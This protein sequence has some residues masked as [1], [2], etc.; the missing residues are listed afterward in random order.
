M[1]MHNGGQR[2]FTLIEMLL[3]V[4]IMG[5][6]ASIISVSVIGLISKGEE[7]GY[8]VDERVLQSAVSVFYADVHQY[9]VGNGGWNEEGNWT[10]A[11]NHPTKS[12]RYLQLREGSKIYIDDH[13]VSVLVNSYGQPATTEEVDDASI[14]IGLLVNKPST[15]TTGLDKAPGSGNSPLHDEHGPYINEVPKSCSGLNHI[16][17]DGS[18][19]WIVGNYGRVYGVFLHQGTWYVGYN[20]QYP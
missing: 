9:A 18:Y 10:S 11:H 2:G 6:L 1:K 7:E 8:E 4:F 3:I 5:L 16:R 17:G 15:R 19:T 20:G 13:E 12:G 14:W